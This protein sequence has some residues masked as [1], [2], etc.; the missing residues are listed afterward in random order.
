M[1]SETL[2]TIELAAKLNVTPGRIRQIAISLNLQRRGRDWLF[3]QQDIDAIAAH[4]RAG[5]EPVQPK[6]KKM[7]RA[8][9]S[10]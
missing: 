1:N 2:S 10:S 5:V 8:E 9:N 7:R 6:R 3:S 4:T